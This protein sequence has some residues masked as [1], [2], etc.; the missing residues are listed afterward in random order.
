MLAVLPLLGGCTR[1][2]PSS[3]GPATLDAV[4]A[5]LESRID[6]VGLDGAG[7]LVVIDGTELRNRA[8]GAYTPETA[9]PIASASKWLTAATM[10][11]LVD[12]GRVSLDD[13][14]STW[15]PAFD[16]TT[17]KA[18]IAQLLSHTSGIE[19]A[20]CIWDPRTTL[21]DCVDSIASRRAAYEPG[22]RFEYGNTSYSVAGRIIEVASGQ[23]FEEAFATRIAGPVGMVATRFTAGS[24]SPT[25]VP[26][27]SAESTLR[28]YGRFVRMLSGDG[29]IDGRRVLSAESVHAMEADAV[30]GI[31]TSRDGAVRTTGIPTYGFGVW[32]DVTGTDDSSAIGSG[33]GAYGFY[34][35]I[36]RARN[37]YGVLLVFDQR[38]SD[39]AVPE[40]QRQVHAVW[41]AIDAMRGGPG[42][43]PTTTYG[44]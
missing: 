4:D 34:P 2:T 41:D 33:N 12:E 40:S 10:M 7:L 11:T 19:Q 29:V 9:V 35:W 26:A 37:G 18:T 6:R 17:G 23:S 31:D 32:R 44:R 15:L 14:V 38:G 3:S 36:D 8:Y 24:R 20:P 22:T 13:S 43:P 25:P 16:G 30:R 27:A 1:G 42:G 39:R 21:A 5:S 28:D